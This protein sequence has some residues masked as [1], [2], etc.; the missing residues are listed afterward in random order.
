M[1]GRGRVA[2][3][4][5]HVAQARHQPHEFQPADHPLQRSPTALELK[6][7][8]R[9]GAVRH[10]LARASAKRTA[11]QLGVVHSAHRRVPLEETSQRQRIRGMPRH[12]DGQRADAAQRQPGIERPEGRPERLGEG[13]RAVRPRWLPD[14]Q[15]A[16]HVRV[17]AEVLGRAVDDGVGSPPKRLAEDRCWH[18]VVDH[19]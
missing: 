16:D 10:Q 9:P 3:C 11:F 18:R 6:G 19:Q 15:A 2:E 17:P 4:G 7:Q 12:P 5:R 14:H 13:A 1:R 8:E